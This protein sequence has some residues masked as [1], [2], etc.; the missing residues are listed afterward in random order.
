M[1]LDRASTIS[2]IASLKHQKFGQVFIPCRFGELD[3]RLIL[4]TEECS[5]DLTLMQLLSDWRKKHEHWFAATFPVSLQRTQRWFEERVHRAEDRLLFMIQVKGRYIGH[6]GL[7]RFEWHRAECEIDNIVRG[8]DAYP[9]IMGISIQHLLDWAR[10]TL[11]IRSFALETTSD[12]PRS[13]QLYERLGFTETKRVAVV[14]KK[15]AE[16]HEWVEPELAQPG[17]IQRYVIHMRLE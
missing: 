2:R 5:L 12:N 11:G 6:V 15:T 9:G 13:L 3:Y 1:T 14:M 10:S 8:E 16:G 17:S 7:F 4:L